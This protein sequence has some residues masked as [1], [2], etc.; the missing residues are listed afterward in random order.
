MFV[1]HD[2]YVEEP[3][4]ARHN[5]GDPVRF[6]PMAFMHPGQTRMGEIPFYLDGSVVYVNEPHRYYI[7]EA[8]CNGYKLR[9]AFKF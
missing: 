9:E 7:A 4:N 2:S 5:I 1:F 3:R 6:A 8:E